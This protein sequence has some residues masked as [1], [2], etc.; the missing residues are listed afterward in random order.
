LQELLEVI[1]TPGAPFLHFVSCGIFHVVVVRPSCPVIK[2]VQ[3]AGVKQAED[4]VRAR[5]VSVLQPQIISWMLE[6]HSVKDL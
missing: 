5:V 6:A 2:P 4:T 1:S 3:A